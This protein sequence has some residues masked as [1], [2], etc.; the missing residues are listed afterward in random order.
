MENAQIET[1]AA[2]GQS[3]S[4]VVLERC[5]FC[6]GESAF[7]KTTYSSKTIREQHWGQDTLHYVNCI[8][9]GTSNRG[10]VGYRTQDEAAKH[11]NTRSNVEVTGAAPEKGL[12]E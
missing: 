1:G 3:R 10:L 5:P 12:S 2:C 9:C 11:W 8:S 6:G 4:T 7:G